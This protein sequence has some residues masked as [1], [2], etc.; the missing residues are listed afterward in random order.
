MEGVN[1]TISGVDVLVADGNQFPL[2]WYISLMVTIGIGIVFRI[3]AYVAL[4]FLHKKD[5]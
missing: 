4:R 2:P 1:A 3:V 5:N